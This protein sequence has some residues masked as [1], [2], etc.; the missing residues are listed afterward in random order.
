VDGNVVSCKWAVDS[1]ASHHICKDRL[2]FVKFK[3]NIYP[4]HVTVA[5]GIEC[6]ILGEGIVEERMLQEDGS[7]KIAKIENVLYIPSMKKNVLSIPQLRKKF[8]TT[9]EGERIKVVWKM[10]CTG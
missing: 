1:G 9:F 6:K 7:I 5:N 4:S 10:R 2:K 3:E 8:V